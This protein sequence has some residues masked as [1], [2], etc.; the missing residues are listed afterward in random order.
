VLLEN[1]VAA[2]AIQAGER[3]NLLVLQGREHWLPDI[4]VK[5]VDATGAGDAFAG[6]LATYL[7]RGRPFAEA[8]R[9]ASTA[10]ALKTTQVGAQTGLPTEADLE[11][12]ADRTRRT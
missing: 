5:A 2:V 3:G 1:G 7:A 11:A 6:T 12:F 10:A 9:L 8:G 4:K